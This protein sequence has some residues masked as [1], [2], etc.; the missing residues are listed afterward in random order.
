M[1]ISLRLRGQF[2]G[3]ILSLV[4][5]TKAVRKDH[6]RTEN[7]SV[8][9][10]A[11]F[12]GNEGFLIWDGL[13]GLPVGPFYFADFD[14]AGSSRR[15]LSVIPPDRPGEWEIAY[16]LN[17]FCNNSVV[18]LAGFSRIAASSRPK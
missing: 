13:T 6:P 17:T 4:S 15:R 3:R 5:G 10:G 2:G 16:L 11:L 18:R 9:P 14:F 7:R 8:F 1:W 12:G